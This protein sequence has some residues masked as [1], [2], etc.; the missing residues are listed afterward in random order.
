MPRSVWEWL[1]WLLVL[2]FPWLLSRDRRDGGFAPL[3]ALM[4]LLYACAYVLV[5]PSGGLL[6][7]ALA[8]CGL[9][10]LDLAAWWAP[11]HLR[12]RLITVVRWPEAKILLTIL[13]ASLVP[14]GLAEEACR[15]LTD[16]HVLSYHRPI[17]TVWRSGHDDWR[18]ATIT[19]DENREPDPV[20]LWRPIAHKPFN[21]QRFKGPV[22]QVPK[23][24]D[25]F[26]VM[27]YGDSL[28][29][30]PTKGGW[31]PWL[32]VLLNQG[33][34]VRD[35]RF[36]VVNAGVAGY[37]SHQGLLRFLQEV[38]RYQPNLVLVSFGWND[39]A[40]AIGQPD[41]SFQ[42]PPWPVVVCQRALIRYR[43]YLA[44]MF[45][46][47]EL[48]PQPPVARAGS[49]QPRVSVEDYLANLERFRA[50]AA[51]RGISIVFLTRPHKLPPAVLLRDPTWRG[52]VPR[53]NAAL[54]AWAARRNVALIDAQHAFEQ[55][56]PALFAD[57]CHFTP[58]GYRRLADLVQDRLRPGLASAVR[59]VG[60][61]TPGDPPSVLFT[62]N[63]HRIAPDLAEQV[64]R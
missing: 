64:L 24:A 26:R 46:T 2:G 25:V 7:T 38:D 21:S 32:H 10:G 18:L 50:E 40:E 23:P 33:T 53:Y 11:P 55:L 1:L 12:Q 13:M 22:P 37:S 60:A 56:P 15:I 6:E 36:E 52:S 62:E 5:V 30:G 43:A 48:R 39:A 29:E 16:L 61:K 41:K 28:T 27:C 17:Q 20:L 49:V 57:E 54:T 45:Y 19:G 14:L 47:R 31:P 51:A 59:I 34:A 4:S 8:A 9:L 3:I 42:I 58:E 63:P 44:L 35:R